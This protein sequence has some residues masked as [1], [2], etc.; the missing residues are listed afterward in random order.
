MFPAALVNHRPPFGWKAC[1]LAVS[2]ALAG[3][4]HGAAEDAHD[5][6]DAGGGVEIG[7]D[8]E[9]DSTPG[10]DAPPDSA[11][12]MDSGARDDAGGGGP[13]ADAGLQPDGRSDSDAGGGADAG[14]NADAGNDAGDGFAMDASGASEAGRDASAC[15]GDLSNVGTGDFHI[16]ATITTVQGGRVALANQR[17][18][19]N[20]GVFWDIRIQ[21]GLLFIET[22]DNVHYTNLVSTGKTVNDGQPH[23]LLVKRAAGT[24]TAYVDGVASGSLS[25]AASLASLPPL[26]SRM[27]PCIGNPNDATV[28][29]VGTIANLCVARP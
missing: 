26:V 12:P 8:A 20:F 6:E 11:S 28:T 24:L 17:S 27:D 7:S 19:C 9:G 1:H 15:T 29:F 10:A 22:D 14:S 4:A 3:C 25:S 5:T 23:D 18:A 16:S 21:N 13:P 2:L